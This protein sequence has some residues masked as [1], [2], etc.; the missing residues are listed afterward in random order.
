[1]VTSGRLPPRKRRPSGGTISPV[2]CHLT[3]DGLEKRLQEGFSRTK[4]GKSGQVN[5]VRWRGQGCS[6]ELF[7]Q[8]YEE[9]GALDK[10]L[11]S[12]ALPVQ[13]RENL[14]K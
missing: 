1:M 13:W 7:G 3:L 11:A 10:R 9:F 12:E 4:T 2:L 14:P 8:L 5:L 6:R